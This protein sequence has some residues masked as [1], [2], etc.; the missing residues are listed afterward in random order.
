MPQPAKPP[1]VERA[2]ASGGR[3]L[4]HRRTPPDVVTEINNLF[5]RAGAVRA[6]S[7]TE[8]TAVFRRH[9]IEAAPLP[10][11]RGQLYRDY[12]LYCLA[13]HHLSA[14]ELAD[15]EHLRTVLRLEDDAVD[16][17]HRRVAREVYSRSVDQVLADATVDAQERE[18]LLRL[19]VHLSIPQGV[20]ENI[21]EMKQR[22]RAAREGGRRGPGTG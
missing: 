19:R 22:Q 14:E 16:L 20:A 8:V 15:L 6:V 10:A 17:V 12:L 13:D 5:A 4:L 7:D 9:G 3:R 2:I 18:F 11:D 1:F 21:L